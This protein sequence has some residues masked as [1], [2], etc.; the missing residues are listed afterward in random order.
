L[1]SSAGYGGILVLGRNSWSSILL[2]LL[3]GWA[4]DLLEEVAEDRSTLVL[5]GGGSLSLGFGL[6]LLLFWLGFSGLSSG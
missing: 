5:S 3:L 4:A 1:G 6:L 2:S